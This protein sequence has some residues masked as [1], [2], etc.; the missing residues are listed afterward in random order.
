MVITVVTE[1]NNEVTE[2][3]GTKTIQRLNRIL[4]LVAAA[5]IYDPGETDLDDEQSVPAIKGL[6]LGDVRL[7]RR[8]TR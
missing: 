1:S 4:Q 5:S 6:D 8:L 3:R 2:L 7:A